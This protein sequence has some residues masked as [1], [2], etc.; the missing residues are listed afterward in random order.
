MSDFSLRLDEPVA[1]RANRRCGWAVS[2]RPRVSRSL[3]SLFSNLRDFLAERPVKI[4]AGTPTRFRRCR[5]WRRSRRK[6]QGVFPFRSAGECKLRA[7]GRLAR[8]AEPVA[9]P[10]RLDR[11]AE[12]AAAEDTSQP[13]PVPEIWSKNTSLR[14]LQALSIAVPAWSLALIICCPCC[15]PERS[16]SPAHEGQDRRGDVTID[17]IFRLICRS[18]R[19]RPRRPAVVAAQHD[20]APAAKGQTAKVCLDPDLAADGEAA[21]GSA[22]HHDANRRGQPDINCPI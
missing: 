22:A 19:P 8:R 7:A 3:R 9:E 18:S 6:P 1:R 13:I 16:M 14:A 4:R 10:A 5:V 2:H 11:A 15:F 21:Q 20:N 12:V 17:N